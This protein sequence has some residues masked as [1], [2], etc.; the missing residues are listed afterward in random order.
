MER[1]VKK[2]IKKLIDRKAN[3]SLKDSF[4]SKKKITIYRHLS[5]I[6]SCVCVCLS[7][8]IVCIETNQNEKQNTS[9]DM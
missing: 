8:G 9:R 5:S 1:N 4:G 3:E 2:K 6:V 7:I